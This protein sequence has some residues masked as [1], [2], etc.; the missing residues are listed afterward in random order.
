MT[1][2]AQSTLIMPSSPETEASLLGTLLLDPACIYEAL[3]KLRAEDF[4]LST[5][6]DIFASIAIL[7]ERQSPVDTR[8][9]CEYLKDRGRLQ[10]CGGVAVI[11][12]LTSGAIR[13]SSVAYHCGVIREKSIM[14]R[15]YRLAEAMQVQAL[16]PIAKSKDIAAQVQEAILQTQ[17]TGTE[18]RRIADVMQ[19][20]V[21]RLSE[22]R[23]LPETGTIGLTTT[24]DE[25]DMGTSGIRESEFWVIGAR[26]NV[27]KTPYGMQIAIAQARKNIPVL[28]FSLEMQDTQIACRCISHA[29]IAKPRYVRDPRQVAPGIWSDIIQAPDIVREWPLFLDDTPR[30]TLRELRHKT[31][32]AVAKYGV[33]LVIVDYLGLVQSPGRSEYDRVTATAAGLRLLARETKC[34]ILSLC[35]LNREAKDLTKEPGLGDLR[36]SGEIEQSANVVGLLHRPPVANSSTEMLGTKGSMIMAKVREGVGGRIDVTFDTDTLTFI[37]GWR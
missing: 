12:E 10:A 33:K 7:T 21:D 34:P 37:G 36:S 8:S 15:L 18:M 20:A 5:N 30:L 32:Y 35:Q 22:Y 17:T 27:G 13:R 11:E 24:L 31:R 29:G 26:P 19:D 16:D 2:P 25:L 1:T 4:Y 14:R 23:S 28:V 6:R 9:L 3:S